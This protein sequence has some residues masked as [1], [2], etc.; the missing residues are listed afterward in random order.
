MFELGII[1]GRIYLEGSWVNGN[2]YIKDGKVAAVSD[3]VLEASE[4]YDAEGKMVLPGFIDP[5][6][7]FELTVGSHTSADDFYNGS[8]AAAYGGITTFIDFIDPAVNISELNAKY[9]QRRTLAEKSIID[10]AL[11]CTIA[12][13][14]DDPKKFAMETVKLGMPTVKLFTTYATTKRRTF[15]RTILSLLKLSKEQRIMLLSHSENDGIVVEG[16]RIPVAEHEQARPAIAEISEVIKLAQM[17]E[18]EDGRMYIVHTNCGTTV[19]R[20]VNSYSSILNQDFILESCPHYFVLSSELYQNDNGYLYTMTPPLR[21]SNEVKK[22]NGYIDYIYTIGTDHCPF[23][24]SEKNKKYVNEIPM[25]IG[26]IEQSF[27]IMYS[28]FG[29]KI[30][31]KFTQN[32]AKAHGLYP[33]KGSL[34]PGSDAD[35]VIFNPDGEHEIG[36][37]HSLCDYTAYSG[38]KVKGSIEST[39]SRGRFVIKEGKLNKSQGEYIPRR[40]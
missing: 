3:T 26:G 25:G 2:I 34:K 19:E 38:F 16:E 27:P 17:T 18:Y 15:D 11:H 7:H 9:N 28:L 33:R 13:I 14:Y 37:Q 40:L 31:D 21:D 36:S 35:I 29:D 4:E 22:L 8:I 39:L 12:E 20:L 5:H 6:V 10:Y 24:S 23:M 1:N 30:I 32:P